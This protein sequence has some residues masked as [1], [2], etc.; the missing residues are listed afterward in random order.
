[1]IFELRQEKTETF[2]DKWYSKH[3]REDI[4]LVYAKIKRS[5]NSPIQDILKVIMRTTIRSCRATTHSDLATLLEPITATYYC[6][7]HGKIRKP[8]FSILSG[9]R[10][11]PKIQLKELQTLIHFRTDTKTTLHN[12]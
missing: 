9:G 5:K 8:L 12:R 10:L 2:L 4:D 6:H 1:M 7:K 11:I 3:I